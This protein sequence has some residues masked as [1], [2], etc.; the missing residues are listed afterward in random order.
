MSQIS[1]KR[2]RTAWQDR[3]R[4]YVVL[5]DG[6]EAARI[7]NGGEAVVDVE[8]GSRSVR[9]EIDWCRSPELRVVVAPGERVQLECEAAANP[10][11]ALLYITLWRNRYIHLRQRPAAA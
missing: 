1:I 11:L 4:D 9:L 7:G 10:F 3:V 6:R 8:P 2:I 5:V